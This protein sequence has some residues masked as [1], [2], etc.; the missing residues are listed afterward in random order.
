MTSV[1]QSMCIHC[2]TPVAKGASASEG[3]FCCLG[4]RMVHALLTAQYLQ[5]YYD[6]RG[7]RG[8][9]VSDLRIERRDYKWLDSIARRVREAT[10]AGLSRVDLDVQGLHCSACVWLIDTLFG[11]RVGAVRVTVNPSLGRAELVV[12]PD[13]D[14]EAFVREVESFG[15]L[16]GP[17][18]KSE[19]VRSRGLVVRMGICIAIAMNSMILGI[20]IYA[21]LASGPIYDLFQ[22]LDLLLSLASVTIGGSV[23]IRSAVQGLRHRVLHLDLPIALGIVLAFAGSVVSYAGHRGGG[24]F[25]DTLNVFIALMLVGR[26]LQ[27]R[28]LE[29]NR[30]ELLANDGSDGLLTRRVRDGHVETVACAQIAVGD[31]LRVAPGD[32]VPVDGTLRDTAAGFSLDWINGESRVR[33]LAPGERVPAGAFL[34]GAQAVEIEACDDFAAS[35]LIEWLRTPATRDADSAMSTPWWRRLAKAYVGAV[36]TAGTVGFLAWLV[37]TRDFARSAEVATAVLIVT[38]PCAFGIAMP[39]A[40][41]LV[42]SGLRRAGL[43]VRVAG[44]LDRAAQV[45]TV[46]F[47]KTGTLTNGTLALRHPEALAWLDSVDRAVLYRL[48]SSSSHPKSMAVHRALSEMVHVSIDVPVREEPGRGVSLRWDS[49]AEFR[50]GAPDWVAPG[51]NAP[52]DLAFGRDGEWLAAFT[53]E[54]TLRPDARAEVAVLRQRGYDVWLLSGDDSARAAQTAHAAGIEPDRV[55]GDAS[56]E[57]KAAWVDAHDHDDLMMIGDGINDSLVVER[58]FC[59]GTPAIDRPFMAARSDFYFVTPGLRPVRLALDAA[60]AL[61][62]VRRRNLAMAVTYN[63]IAVALAYAGLMSPLL[64]AVLMPASSVSTI[65][66]TTWSL[67]ARSRLWRS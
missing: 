4:C 43:F 27:E 38:C 5:R 48:A 49:G 12:A 13:F 65:V 19:P 34:A 39:L 42:Q 40:Y 1:A 54:E 53:T 52:G 58:A 37:A 63:V 18:L 55:V 21:G 16:L 35:P 22:R 60:R 47:D 8:V 11:R 29:K 20:A 33:T 44:F 51:A 56:P 23:F 7:E 14:L 45:H 66:A 6:L 62:R 24:I 10:A 2:G 59:S 50:L 9:P 28:V 46:V 57:A 25:V 61:A 41:D 26:F 64:C 67:N 32:L 31:R 15:Y 17:P 3:A 36:L 30:L